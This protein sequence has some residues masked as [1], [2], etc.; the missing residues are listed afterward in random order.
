MKLRYC[1]LILIAFCFASL[2][3]KAQ[4]S[5]FP[6]YS[7]DFES[8]GGGWTVSGQNASWQWGTPT[9]SPYTPVGSGSRCWKTNLSGNY[10]V[11]EC[12]FLTSPQF[13][14]SCY[15]SDPTISFYLIFNIE[16]TWDG[17]QLQLSTD[18]GSTWSVVG[19]STS[20]GT[21]WY[22]GSNSYGACGALG[23]D[24]GG[25]GPGGSQ[26][27]KV[28]SHVLTGTAGK[29]NV[30]VRFEMTSDGSVTYA[31]AAIDLI[32]ITAAPPTLVSPLN[33]ATD[34]PFSTNLV[35]STPPPS[36]SGLTHDLQVTTDPSFAT[37]SQSITGISGNNYTVNGLAAYTD[38][39]WRVRY[40]RSGSVGAWSA[41]RTFKTMSLAPPAPI[42]SSPISGSTAQ[43]L[44][45]TISCLTTAYATSY[46]FQVS[47]V[48]SFATTILDQTISGTSLTLSGLSNYTTYYWRVQAGNNMGFG[49]WSATWYFRSIV[50]TP[51]L[52]SPT[53]GTQG[54]NMPF[55]IQWNS[56]IGASSY[57]MQASDN[58]N[59]SNIAL[60]TI[61]SGTTSIVNNITNNT[62]F[63]WRVRALVG[64]S[65]IGKWSLVWNFS[66]VIGV[67]TLALPL[68]GTTDLPSQ[69]LRI[70]WNPVV[71]LAYY[72]V[73]VATDFLFKN[74]VFEKANIDS[75]SIITTGLQPNTLYYWRAQASNP[76]T[77]ISG[78]SAPN[79]F[80]TV[81]NSVQAIA[82]ANAAKGVQLPVTLQWSSAGD[83]VTYRIQVADNPKFAK[84]AINEDKVG[85]FFDVYGSNAG[86]KNYTT[87][88]WRVK[89]I[90][91]TGIDVAWSAV[92]TFTTILGSPVP[93]S[94]ANGSD[95]Q[96]INAK[97]T[98]KAPAGAVKYTV[99]VYEDNASQN[100][101][102][103]D[104]AVIGVSTNP[105]G[106]KP[107]TKYVWTVQAVDADN[108]GS[109][110]SESWKFATTTMA[111]AA[112]ALDKPANNAS[113][114]A[115]ETKL[116][117]KASE[118]AQ[119]YDVQVSTASNFSSTV[120][121]LTGVA[122]TS[123]SSNNLAYGQRYFWRVRAV[124]AAGASAWSETWT[125][126]VAPAKPSMVALLSPP[127][128]S[129]NQEYTVSLVWNNISNAETYQ[130]QVS[131]TNDFAATKLDK[132][133][134]PV[135]SY[136]AT[137]L[138]EKT[139]YYWRVRATNP[140][141]DGAWSDVWSFSTKQAPSST[142]EE[143]AELGIHLDE[144]YPNPTSNSITLGF[145]LEK[146]S[147]ASITIVNNLGEIVATF[148]SGFYSK[149]HYS[150]MWNVDDI[151]TGT[152]SVR[153]NC[154]G[155]TSS[156]LLNIV[157]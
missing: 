86:L 113:D 132:M 139:T 91:L 19:T 40:N 50:G 79:T 124:N 117:W 120:I 32:Q 116:E 18:G 31:G 39:Y 43:M 134:L 94:P 101:V 147:N 6:S 137:G 11:N 37:I 136:P 13:D 77:G 105:T 85:E 28:A 1:V 17:L 63:F 5:A 123:Y 88:Y 29:P 78:W 81:V 26:T 130:V 122:E 24:W 73:Q 149:G 70:S 89:P 93:V 46:H 71:G 118:F 3:T 127:N 92:Q 143:L 66:T 99:R 12:A 38:Y 4:I 22:N 67:P 55:T 52:V 145:S 9:T 33:G 87:Y 61:Q 100:L 141:G 95:N 48:S 129:E 82:P 47:T 90:S 106:L 155:A 68:D 142:L 103:E 53:T 56:V 15:G 35:W 102:F 128:G 10:N 150:L 57:E 59:F 151:P 146:P 112:P 27:W 114:A 69:S 108:F 119:S 34:L 104:N 111:A 144:V 109:E 131:E 84:P 152:Y 44:D 96:K 126:V 140:S 156:Q 16:N 8:S 148:G 58:I 115:P 98:W 20:G 54:L 107:E 14:F 121:N 154:G 72:R 125:F 2:Q 49:P 153:L 76:K 97:L 60:S 25:V 75:V 65:E 133:G 21:N 157:K 62:Q 7:E 83:R 64:V 45:G 135:T 30:R 110:W 80:R 74:I 41:S 42:L 138:K 23:V 51:Q 36:C